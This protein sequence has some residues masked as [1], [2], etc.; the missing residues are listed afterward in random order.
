MDDDDD[1]DKR[2]IILWGHEDGNNYLGK[3]EDSMKK[4]QM[5]HVFKIVYKSFMGEMSS[6]R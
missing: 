5:S 6:E 3:L 2:I 1:D 4:L